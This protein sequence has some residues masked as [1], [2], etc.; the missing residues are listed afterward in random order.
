MQLPVSTI[1]R[2]VTGMSSR[3]RSVDGIA[4]SIQ[5]VAVRTPGTCSARTIAPKCASAPVGPTRVI[6]SE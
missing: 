1:S 6:S 5:S 4:A 3:V 2:R